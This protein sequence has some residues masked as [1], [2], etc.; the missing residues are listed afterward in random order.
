MSNLTMVIDRSKERIMKEL[1]NFLDE[2]CGLIATNNKGELCTKA[3]IVRTYLNYTM[4]QMVKRNKDNV[5]NS[6]KEYTKRNNME[7]ISIGPNEY[8]I[9]KING[10]GYRYFGLGWIERP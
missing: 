5:F 7:I 2:R 6:L 10:T 9:S 1:E 3:N 4:K 8:I